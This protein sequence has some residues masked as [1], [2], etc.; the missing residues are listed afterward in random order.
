MIFLAKNSS[1]REESLFSLKQFLKNDSQ[2]NH[3][4]GGARPKVYE[5][6]CRTPKPSENHDA[7]KYTR[8]P[9]EL[10][11]FVLDHLVT[12]MCYLQDKTSTNTVNTEPDNLPDF[13]LNSVEKKRYCND[14]RKKIPD[15][16]DYR[17]LDLTDQL[18]TNQQPTNF[19]HPSSLDL[20]KQDVTD[21][22]SVD[23]PESVG[24]YF[25]F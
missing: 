11:D 15:C 18:D 20:P 3:Q 14:Q 1:Q 10:P 7:G 16:S 9:T 13:T 19:S 5:R 17:S 8:N 4:F 21:G 12:E 25:N 23:I 22:Q 2:T 6:Q 24:M